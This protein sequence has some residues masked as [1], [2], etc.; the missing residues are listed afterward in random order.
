MSVCLSVPQQDVECSGC[1]DKLHIAQ[2][3]GGMSAGGG[4]RRQ[5]SAALHDPW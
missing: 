3:Q 5:K 1:A 4:C 2:T